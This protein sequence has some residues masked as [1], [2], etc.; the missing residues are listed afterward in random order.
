[1]NE[2]KWKDGPPPSKGWWIASVTQNPWYLRWWDG[3][4]WSTCVLKTDSP[5]AASRAAKMKVDSTFVQWLP[6]PADWPERSKT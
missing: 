2:P 3:E 5:Q 1:M 6:R 4:T